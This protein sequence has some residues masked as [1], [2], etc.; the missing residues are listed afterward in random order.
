MRPVFSTVAENYHLPRSS[1]GKSG[2]F[3]AI[4]CVHRPVTGPDDFYATG[5]PAGDSG[6]GSVIPASA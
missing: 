4:S 5:W 2:A 3:T 6:A 1:K